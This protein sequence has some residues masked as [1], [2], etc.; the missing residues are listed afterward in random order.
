MI[1][2]DQLKLYAEADT[3][4]ASEGSALHLICMSLR[5]T[6]TFGCDSAPAKSP[7]CD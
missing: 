1:V 7:G 2:C 3:I 4:I 6:A 5:E